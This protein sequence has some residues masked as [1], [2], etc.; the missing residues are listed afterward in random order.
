L[1]HLQPR[2]HQ[3]E[4]PFQTFNKKTSKTHDGS[5]GRTTYLPT[6]W[7]I[8]DW[9]LKI[10]QLKGKIIFQTSIFGH[11]HTC[12]MSIFQGV[13]LPQKINQSGIYPKDPITLSDDDWGV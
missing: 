11:V 6:P 13:H 1:P 5:M 9:N 3:Q 4:K 7:K 12:S 2:K 8:N 10:T